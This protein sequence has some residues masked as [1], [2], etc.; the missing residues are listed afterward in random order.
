MS[1]QYFWLNEKIDC[2]LDTFF[3]PERK[4]VSAIK[5]WL[6]EPPY[7][8]LHITGPEKSG[9]THLLFAIINELKNDPILFISQKTPKSSDLTAYFEIPVLILDNLDYL[10]NHTIPAESFIDLY[11]HR[12]NNNLPMLTAA[13]DMLPL[14]SREDVISRMHTAITLETPQTYSDNHLYQL[15]Q[16][17]TKRY[18]YELN[19]TLSKKI[20]EQHNRQTSVQIDIIFSYLGYLQTHQKT[21]NRSSLSDF[22]KVLG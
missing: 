9:K 8:H 11:N 6:A 20:I 21:P 13:R 2:H 4:I 5:S 17:I 18:G 3:D 15:H 10:I 19:E 22:L 1:Q 12:L 16:I 14:A 7:F